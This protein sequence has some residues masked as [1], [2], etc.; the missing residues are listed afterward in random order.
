MR[1]VMISSTDATSLKIKEILN[2]LT[3]DACA[4]ILEQGAEMDGIV[5]QWSLDMRYRGQSHELNIST[6]LNAKDIIR[7]SKKRFET[8]HKASYGYRM[9]DREIQ[10]VTAR[11][12]ARY[13]QAD[14]KSSGPATRSVSEPV[15]FREVIV[16]SGKKVQSEIYRRE[17]IGLGQSIV[18]PAVI[19]QLDTT[20]YI[21]PKWIG[22]SKK[23]GSIWLRRV[24]G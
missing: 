1:T 14:W 6:P 11:V 17:K 8:E 21:A 15:G 18:G 12:T 19:E 20:T 23:D 7:D 9:K 16:E 4:Q 2:D 5:L 13:P 22:K 10:W 24:S 3:A